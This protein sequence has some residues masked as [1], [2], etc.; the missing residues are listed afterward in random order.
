MHAMRRNS[1]CGSSQRWL[2]PCPSSAT[3][4]TTM[5]VSNHRST[6]LGTGRAAGRAVCGRPQLWVTA[7]LLCG[8]VTM[9]CPLPAGA[10]L[11]NRFVF[12]ELVDSGTGRP[13][14]GPGPCGREGWPMQACSG[15]L[16][17]RTWTGGQH[18]EGE[19][20]PGLQASHCISHLPA[21][22][23]R[24]ASGMQLTHFLRM[25]QASGTL[26]S[27]ACM[28]GTTQLGRPELVCCWLYWHKGNRRGIPKAHTN[29]AYNS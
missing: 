16:R 13:G 4:Q 25:C 7:S 22:V 24:K 29:S 1:W 28:H 26:A 6:I 2:Q 15:D 5:Q 20:L 12:Y 10:P 27:A 14:T 11:Y 23:R 8:P 19:E 17:L 21:G 3:V 9:A 18:G